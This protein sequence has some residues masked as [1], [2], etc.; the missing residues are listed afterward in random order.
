M[1][2][3]FFGGFQC[4]P[5]DD[6]PAAS[7]DSGVLAR[8]SES[9]FFYYIYS[10]TDSFFIYINLFI[11]LFLAALGLCCCIW[12]FSSCVERGYSSL[13]CT[14]SSL[15]I[16]GERE[17]RSQD[18]C[19]QKNSTASVKRLPLIKIDNL[20]IEKNFNGLNNSNMFKLMTS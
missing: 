6:C 11:Y 14:G 10:F 8:G 9:T 19:S 20:S 13:W 17:E 1:W 2:G 7:C 3:I 18:Y 12:A 15:N 4:L 16:N 5:V